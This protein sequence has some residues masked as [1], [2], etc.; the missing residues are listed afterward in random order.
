MRDYII[1]GVPLR[2]PQNK[3]TIDHTRSRTLA[4][5]SRD[6]E[7]SAI[8]GMHGAVDSVE[9]FFTS[10]KETIVLN[11]IGD[12]KEELNANLRGLVGLLQRRS[13]TAVSAPQRTALVGAGVDRNARTF[14]VDPDLIR[15]ASC[16]T[17]GSIA[18]EYI[19]ETTYRITAIVEKINA[20]W[21]S[22]EE[23][24]ST[25]EALAPGTTVMDLS[26]IAGDSE[27]PITRGMVRVQGPLPEGA[28]VTFVDGTNYRRSIGFETGDAVTSGQW[29]LVDFATCTAR[30]KNTDDWNL[31]TGTDLTSWLG[32]A[33]DGAFFLS[34]QSALATFPE[35][36]FAYSSTVLQGSATGANVEFRIRRSYL[37]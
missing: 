9:S 15:S 34:P 8:Y 11:V 23:Y 33:G 22:S 13:Y 3:W 29:V 28:Q 17:Y 26:E 2:D 12:D 18:S 14:D 21:F 20:F 31:L 35:V 37:S 7:S 10:G 24:T 5:I 36:S 1:D 19:N 27:A 4:E 25:A 6:I 32:V 16:R 30:L